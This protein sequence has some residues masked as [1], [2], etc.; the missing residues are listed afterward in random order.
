[1]VLKDAQEYVSLENSTSGTN[2]RKIGLVMVPGDHIEK[3]EL[4]NATPE[5]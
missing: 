1:M 2:E 5:Q 4:Q 3:V